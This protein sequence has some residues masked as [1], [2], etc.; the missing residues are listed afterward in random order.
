MWNNWHPP[1]FLMGMQTNMDPGENHS[2]VIQHFPRIYPK[3]IETI[4]TKKICT[5]MFTQGSRG[6]SCV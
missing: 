3:E 4:F 1:V 5:R 6:S 2:P